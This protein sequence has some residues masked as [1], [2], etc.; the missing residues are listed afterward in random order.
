MHHRFATVCVGALL[1]GA[2]AAAAVTWVGDSVGMILEGMF[3]V[4]LRSWE[5]VA[6]QVLFLNVPAGALVALLGALSGN[7]RQGLATGA[8]VHAVVF[9]SLVT[10]DESFGAAPVSVCCWALVVGILGGAAAGAAGAV[11][12][13]AAHRHSSSLRRSLLP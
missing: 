4:N 7:W 8:A 12:V 1:A 5:L 10:L 9:V 11:L 13:R 3:P 2:V 6:L